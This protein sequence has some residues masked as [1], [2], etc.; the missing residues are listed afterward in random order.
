VV[1]FLLLQV[2]FCND[3]ILKLALGNKERK[4]KLF[5]CAFD[6]SHVHFWV[7]IIVE[8]DEQKIRRWDKW[9]GAGQLRYC[10]MMVIL[11]KI[12]K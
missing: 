11:S 1:T 5:L 9:R 7:K 3:E 4:H 2:I 12:C 10:A 8:G 6:V